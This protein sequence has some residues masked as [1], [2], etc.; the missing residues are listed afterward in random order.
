MGFTDWLKGLVSAPTEVV[1]D[2][3]QQYIDDATLDKILS[4]LVLYRTRLNRP[5]PIKLNALKQIY[6]NLY[7]EDTLIILD[8]EKHIWNKYLE[9]KI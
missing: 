6:K 7:R 4:D 2:E 8:E 1:D 9:N 3:V 5:E